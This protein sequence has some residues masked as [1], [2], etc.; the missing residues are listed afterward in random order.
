MG[1]GWKAVARSLR[2]YRLD[3]GHAA[4]LRALYRPFVSPGDLVFDVGAH[5]GDR[6]AAFR[7]LGARVVA[8]EPQP[9]LARV[10]R[11]LHGRDAGVTVVE[12]AL[13][14]APGTASLRVNAA[15]PTVSTLSERFVAAAAGAPG[16]EGQRWDAEQTVAVDT[17]DRL[18]AA[19]GSPAFVKIDV[20]GFEAEVMAGLSAP[21]PA[22]SFE[23]VTAAREAAAEALERARALGYRGF[24]LS[25]R[26]SHA[27]ATDWIGGAAMAA[28]LAALPDE[29]NSG[30]VY[31]R[32]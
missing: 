12:A 4:G 32:L 28:A 22:L 7:A 19:N 15:N 31:C 14:P 11:L 18:I 9:R 20:E 1:P 10:L 21:P 6:V 5:V 8:V 13:G 25:L 2:V 26:E 24:R 23:V 29:A 3:R 27:W 16:W 17:L 30:D